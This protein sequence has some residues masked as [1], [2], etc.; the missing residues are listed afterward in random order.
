MKSKANL[1][2]HDIFAFYESFPEMSED[3]FYLNR[4][5]HPYDYQ[6]VTYSQRNPMKYMTISFKGVTLYHEKE[7]EFMTKD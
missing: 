7:A 1:K 3:F 2:P 6:I 4:V 5:G